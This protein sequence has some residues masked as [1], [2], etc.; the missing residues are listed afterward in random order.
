MRRYQQGEIAA[1]DSLYDLLAGRVYGYLRSRTN[2]RAEADDVFQAVFLKL[3]QSRH[4]YDAKQA[5]MPWFWSIIRTAR[6]DRLRREMK[7][8]A[9]ANAFEAESR[10]WLESLLASDT[11]APATAA[12][13]EGVLAELKPDQREILEL[14]YSEG[15]SFEQISSKLKISPENARQKISRLIKHLRKSWAGGTPS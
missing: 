11:R 5:F 9:K 8:P 13:P 1:F 14:R 2:S 3:H 10:N 12:V 4:Q 15:L 6:L 7:N